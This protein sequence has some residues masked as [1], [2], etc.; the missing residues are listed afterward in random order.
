MRALE[1]EG[2]YS[3]I[4]QLRT[5]KESGLEESQVPN[6]LE[7]KALVERCSSLLVKL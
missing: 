6:L 3:Q 1:V 4:S 5:E 7:H 2:K